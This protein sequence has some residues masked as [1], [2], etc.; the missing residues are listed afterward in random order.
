MQR[1]KIRRGKITTDVDILRYIGASMH[2]S[3]KAPDNYKVHPIVHQPLEQVDKIVA[4]SLFAFRSLSTVSSA[5]WCRLIRS[6]TL[7]RRLSTIMET[8]MPWSMAACTEPVCRAL[9]LPLTFS[10]DFPTITSI[11][12]VL[13]AISIRKYSEPSQNST[14]ECKNSKSVKETIGIRQAC[15][16]ERVCRSFSSAGR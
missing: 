8:S 10:F 4:H 11:I 9:F 14:L 16:V 6:V 3:C 13:I 1:K 7:L 5:N 15:G 12:D 2:D